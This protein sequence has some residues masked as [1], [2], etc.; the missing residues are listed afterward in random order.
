MENQPPPQPGPHPDSGAN[1]PSAGSPSTAH[2]PPHV[3]VNLPDKIFVQPPRRRFGRWFAVLGWVLFVLCIPTILGKQAQTEEYFGADKKIAERYH[4][5]SKSAANRVAI[6]EVRG[7]I[8]EGTGYVKN[9]IDRVRNDDNVQGVVL[10]INS[11]GGTVSG[12]DYI[13]YQLT[14]LVKAREIPLVVS[15]G[16]LAASGGYYIAMAV[17]DQEDS[18]FA[19]P[20]TTT[21]SIGV[22]MPHYDL[23]GL[24]ADYHVKNDAI[25]SHPRKQ[26]LSMT[27]EIS[28]EDR[29]VLQRYVDQAFDRFKGIVMD[30]RPAFKKDPTKLDAVATG[31]IF[32]A[33]Q[34]EIDGLVDKIGF[35]DDAID[36]C[37][38]LT[39]FDPEDIRV[40]SYK[41]PTTF[42]EAAGISIV[43]KD[44]QMQLLEMTVPQVYYMLTTLPGLTPMTTAE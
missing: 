30:G 34:A 21:G 12:S 44:P 39:G 27:R 23:S 41:R 22:I 16:P 35:L 32:S 5:G 17:G 28:P 38:E 43:Q 13:Y 29:E 37:I 33:E 40:V 3:T 31:E 6:I 10:R 42:L 9:Q 25:V 36:R 4:S 11:P 2:V 1:A 26:L 8:M 14:E 24:L 15:M 7:A 20:T 19:E 18:I